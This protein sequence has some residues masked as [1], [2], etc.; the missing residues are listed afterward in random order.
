M[1]TITTMTLLWRQQGMTG[2]AAYQADSCR[3]L[4]S[5]KSR[6]V[7]ACGWWKH[8]KI[9]CL[10]SG[11]FQRQTGGKDT[12]PFALSWLRAWILFNIS[13]FPSST[14]KVQLSKLLL[15]PSTFSVER[16]SLTLFRHHPIAP[17]KMRCKPKWQAGKHT[18]LGIWK[19]YLYLMAKFFCFLKKI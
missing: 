13:L 8:R 17:A 2:A 15:S 11:M 7:V 5:N 12:S 19:S 18:L 10:T 9:L 16:G 3:W 6:Q 4:P 14:G 1:N